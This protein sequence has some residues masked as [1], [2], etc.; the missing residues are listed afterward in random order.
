M[1]MSFQLLSIYWNIVIWILKVVVIMEV[2]TSVLN[3]NF[4]IIIDGND[5]I[6]FDAITFA[7][8]R[9]VC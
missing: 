7:S 8:T 6:I 3:N 1:S 4:C 5:N 2:A 9:E